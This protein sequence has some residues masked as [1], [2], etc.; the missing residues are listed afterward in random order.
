M[1]ITDRGKPTHVLLTYEDYEKLA[2][3]KSLLEILSYPPGI[4]DIDIEFPRIDELPR[5]LDLD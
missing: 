5:P 3:R 1:F 2:P 4:E